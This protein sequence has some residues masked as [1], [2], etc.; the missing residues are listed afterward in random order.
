MDCTVV[1][2]HNGGMLTTHPSVSHLQLVKEA[3]SYSIISVSYV[4]RVFFNMMTL[5]NNLTCHHTV[6]A[7]ICG[8]A[9]HSIINN[10]QLT[11]PNKIIQSDN[12]WQ[13]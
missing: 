1:C 10:Q 6:N 7:T 12:I 3:A 9:D 11:K 8:E 13:K 2:F 5:V 4:L